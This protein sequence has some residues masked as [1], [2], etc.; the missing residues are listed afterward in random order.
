MTDDIVFSAGT[1]AANVGGVALLAAGE[2]GFTGVSSYNLVFLPTYTA[3][4][5][6]AD[7]DGSGGINDVA[8]VEQQLGALFVLLNPNRPNF[9]VSTIIV[10]D[11][12]TAFQ[13]TPTSATAFRGANGMN[14]LAI[15]DIG[16][17]TAN[18][19]FGQIVVGLNDGTGLFLDI[20]QFRQFVATPGITNISGGDFDNNGIEDLAFI[21][22]GSN[23]AGIALNDGTDFFLTPSFRETGGFQPV[24]FAVGDVNDDD[25]L[26][27]MALNQGIGNQF[28]NSIVSVLLGQGNGQLVPTGSL[29]NVNNFG[30]SIVGGLQEV[31][32]D[33]RGRIV[34]LN[35][36]RQVDFNNDGF[37]DVAVCS[38][39]G[40][41]GPA[42]SG[43]PTVTLLLNRPESPGSFNVQLPIELV[44][45]TPATTLNLTFPLFVSGRGG[46]I[47]TLNSPVALGAGGARGGANYLMSVGDYNADGSPDLVVTGSQTIG[48]A[49]FRS[50]LYLIG[51]NSAGTMRVARPIR[52]GNYGG[53]NV[54]LAGGDTFV[55]CST[56]EFAPLA[57]IVPDVLHLSLN[58]NLWV[59][60]NQTSV[61]NHA[62]ILTI[63]R[64]TALNAP[65]PGGGRKAIITAGQAL[66]IPISGQD[67][68]RGDV[69]SFSLV[70]PPT[71]ENPPSFIMLRD[72]GNNTATLSIPA[73]ADIN[74][75]PGQARFRIAVEATDLRNAGPGGRLPLT[76]RTFFTLIV[77]PNAPPTI[78]AI[79]NQAVVAGTPTTVN[80]NISDAQGQMVTATVA[81]DRG[82]FVTVNGTTLS[83]NAGAGDVGTATC[84]VTATDQFGLAS[85]ASFVVTV[86]AANVAP[87]IANIADQ[88]VRAGDVRTV[89][90][91]ASDANGPAGLR[92]AITSAPSFVS[93]ADNGNGTGTIRIAPAVTDTTGG[94]VTVQVTDPQ[95]L[96][97]M[98]SFNVTVQ[99][100]VNINAASRAKPNLF[101]SGIG[102]GSSGATVSVNGQNVS[103][104]I[105]GQSDTSITLKGSNRR[106]NLRSGPNQ[107]TVTSGGTTSNTFVLNLVNADEE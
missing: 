99:R 23:F 15:T 65:F 89:T 26:D 39:R 22:F 105:I 31:N 50:S 88:T 82:N 16:T 18:S 81:C 86:S 85:T 25:N 98:A 27:L 14:N 30:V 38:T 44:D 41:S 21:D 77:N 9:Q 56:G 62:P 59:D 107:I 71:G 36:G 54:K 101:I 2:P 90:V 40:G 4:S 63:D 93:I 68:D 83:I 103:A 55:S 75:G 37:P 6:T 17:P 84:T 3:T 104:R 106:L 33:G 57:N 1:S 51:N 11:L 29:L 7:F 13:V 8:I 61:L 97:A 95:G 102:F 46:R 100:A 49:N 76:G 12:F 19:G 48:I 94:R 52:T 20:F 34:N 73:G 74:R 58:G 66:S 78:G 79:A 60:Q 92:L 53:T 67:V 24:S 10:A 35:T 87:T 80:L 43:T 72:N 5:L 96:S 70:A 91:M 47:T 64:R 45:D 32:A 42:N 28:N 69:L